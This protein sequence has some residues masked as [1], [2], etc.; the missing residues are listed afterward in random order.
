MG[1]ES[2]VIRSTFLSSELL[3][4]N[5]SEPVVIVGNAPHDRPGV[6]VSHLIG[7]RASFLGTEAP[8]RRPRV[9]QVSGTT[10]P[11]LCEASSSISGI[12]SIGIGR[13][14][15][16]WRLSSPPLECMSECAHLM[17]AEQSRNL[18]YMHLAV[19][20]VTNR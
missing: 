11:P 13:S 7:N 4:G 14:Q 16:A 3:L 17:K 1:L 20:E 15:L 12:C 9:R 10:T 5:L 19:V 18:G 2:I 8:M 6:L